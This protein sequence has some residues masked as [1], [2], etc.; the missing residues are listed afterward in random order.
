[1]QD[2]DSILQK[3]ENE[4]DVKD[5][6]KA[7]ADLII[8]RLKSTKDSFGYW[9]KFCFANAII[10]LNS[11]INLL[12]QP[13]TFLFRICLYNLEK[14]FIPATERDESYTRRDKQIDSLTYEQFMEEL[15]SIRNQ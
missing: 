8:D 12:H 7:I 9:E 13:R 4:G 5:I 3:L 1:M 2:I 6:R 10:N 11:N 15:E 14:A